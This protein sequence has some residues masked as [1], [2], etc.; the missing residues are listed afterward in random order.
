MCLFCGGL[1]RPVRSGQRGAHIAKIS[2]AGFG[3]TAKHAVARHRRPE[4]G[5]VSRGKIRRPPRLAIGPRRSD[6][7]RYRGS[8]DPEPGA[9]LPT[10]DRQAR[11]AGKLLRGQLERMAVP[12]G[13]I[14]DLRREQAEPQDPGGVG[15]TET[16]I[17]RA[18]LPDRAA[19]IIRRRRSRELPYPIS[20]LQYRCPQ[21][22]GGTANHQS[23][24]ASFRTCSRKIIDPAL[25]CVSTRF[26]FRIK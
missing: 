26:Q 6:S 21:H 16:R 12:E 22:Y 18:G 10:C 25:R 24:F 17:A 3:G 8:G 9:L 20:C 11:A 4:C 15:A 13:G 5:S 1:L 23:R 19:S 14:H 2:Y 7:N